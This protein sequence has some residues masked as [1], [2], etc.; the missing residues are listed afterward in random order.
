MSYRSWRL[1]TLCVEAV[2]NVFGRG[3]RLRIVALLFVAVGSALSLLSLNEWRQLDNDVT[4]LQRQ[5][6]TTYL[7][8]VDSENNNSIS[9][10]SCSR[11]ATADGV[12]SVAAIGQRTLQQ[13]TQLGPRTIPIVAVGMSAEQH[14]LR[15]TA[16]TTDGIPVMAGH[17]LAKTL[18]QVRTLT[19]THG[20]TYQI[21]Q[22]I[23]N[24]LALA[25]LDGSIVIP[26]PL[27]RMSGNV[28]NCLVTVTP[29]SD[30]AIGLRLASSIS[31]TTLQVSTQ[32]VL[33][34]IGTHPYNRF[35]HRPGLA[36]YPAIGTLLALVIAL[37]YR[38]RASELGI[39]RIA[40]TS[41]L[42]L[43]VLLGLENGLLLGCWALSAATSSL[44]VEHL[45]SFP[46]TA[47]WERQLGALGICSLL[48]VVLATIAANRDVTTMLKDR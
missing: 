48:S 1:S 24:D 13:F 9:A 45:T 12:T 29:S 4:A 5:G 16:P 33:T 44:A 37:T 7:I 11:L 38:S 31:A 8:G 25:N 41:R 21:T 46:T 36:V 43:L 35:L 32:R 40:G 23:P 3:S 26:L 34:S 18:E 19:A 17:D 10:P 30:D 6:W 15:D 47:T 2:R 42:A 14:D 28:H 20:T 27:P 39:Y 22:L